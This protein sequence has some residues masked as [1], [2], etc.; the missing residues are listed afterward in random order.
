MG[1][2]S[3]NILLKVQEV[4]ISDD[5]VFLVYPSLRATHKPLSELDTVLDESQITRIV[6]KL[7]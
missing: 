5:K 4:F 2:I 3:H 1:G 6:E 7:I